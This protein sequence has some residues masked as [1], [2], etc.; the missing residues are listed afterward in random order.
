MWIISLTLACFVIF[1]TRGWQ[2]RLT[3]KRWRTTLA[4][5][6][7][8]AIYQQLDADV[9][10]FTLSQTARAKR[11]AIEYVYGEI[12]FESF[13]AL[14]SLCKPNRSTIFYDLG[15]GTGKAVLACA[16]VFEVQKSCGIE[17][18]SLLDHCAKQQ[19]QR[20]KLIPEYRLQ[21]NRIEFRQGDM[22]ENQFSDATLL[23]IN[24]T[25]FFGE[26]WC[27]ISK[28]VEQI[29]PGTLVITT[30]KTLHS[31]LFRTIRQTAVKMSWG[32]VDAFIQQ[33]QPNNIPNPC[34]SQD[35]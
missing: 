11:D 17:F 35:I 2:Q 3:L 30:S 6:K 34:F 4:L 1:F 24:S 23:F 18:F 12:D 31:Q 32:I 16:M 29:K 19:Q 22:L 21:A 27:A 9:D 20:L 5:D 13:I 25:A 7:H 15:S 14:L 33:R 8:A 10:G 26:T 28:Q